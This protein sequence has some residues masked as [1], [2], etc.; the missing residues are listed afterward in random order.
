MANGNRH[1]DPLGVA[2]IDAHVSDKWAAE[3]FQD[4][5][6]PRVLLGAMFIAIVMLPGLIYMGLVVGSDVGA[7]AEWVTV[8]LF[9]E[10][11][12]RG[13]QKLRRQELYII[14]HTAQTLTAMMGGVMLSGGVFAH[15][16]W[17]RY[18][19]LSEA[20]HN[21][22]LTEQMPPWF[23]PPVELLKN[24]TFFQE[25][26]L[27]AIIVA[28]FAMVL[29]RVQF[30][31]L[32]Y[33]MFRITSDVE[34]LPFPLARVGAEGATAL[35]ESEEDDKQKSGSWRWSVFS[36]MAVVGMVWGLIYMGIP[37]LSGALFGTPVE[38]I[39][40]PF[41][42]LTPFTEDILPSAALAV[43]FNLGLVLMAFILPWR[44][45][46]GST[47]ACLLCQ[48]VAAP[49]LYRLGVHEQWKHGFSALDTQLAN[50]LDL[51][52]S[53]GIGGALSV[54]VTG[55]WMAVRASRKRRRDG[56]GGYNWKALATT[57]EGRGDWPIWI[58]ALVFV[59]CALGFVTL[60]HGIL[61]LGW[62]GGA[63]KPHDERFPL[64]ILLVFAF[65]W[66]PVNTYIHA[67]LAGITGQH[68]PIP[69]VREGAF[70]MSGYRHPDVWVAP[71]PVKDYGHAAMLFKQV[72]LTRTRF[73]SVVKAEVV[74][75]VILTVAGLF[76]WSYL[77]NLGS[78][79]STSYPFAQEMW[80]FLAKNA[81]LW[82]SALG[83]GNDQIRSAIQPEVILGALVVFV[84]LFGALRWLGIPLAY[85]FGAVAGVG[86]F[87]YI[88]A[89]MLI[90]LG[91][92]VVASRK[93]GKE[94]LSRYAPVMMAGFAAGFGM[95]GMLVVAIVLVKSAISAVPY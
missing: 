44:V 34:K 37:S 70:L 61:N 13:H 78:I 88:A 4:G 20:F 28:V 72:E 21:F 46:V 75:L 57:P 40:I 2:D 73:T 16:I 19:K 18:L 26:W 47:T 3:P 33:I 90:G 50:G 30:F 41:L 49:V 92:R 25:A 89:A 11:A 23:A 86:Q 60:C 59:V 81:A 43:G 83:E 29:T 22:N 74:A 79:P 95:A 45:V 1:R 38:L 64:W 53:V 7:G 27:P 63:A 32:G 9:L 82:T 6:T 56:G 76:Y 80:P 31:G 58:S 14:L 68:I 24:R 65:L 48:V 66:T 15:L 54:A 42:D 71:V 94:K 85:Y 69:F 52:M 51:W 87:P 84:L 17:N 55:I 91:V 36:T 35:A 77:L 39:P 62:L 5:F 8:L 93:F 12:R 10:L 67:R